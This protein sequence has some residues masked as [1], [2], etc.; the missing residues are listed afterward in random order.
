MII[1]MFVI[2]AI[3]A[4][5]IGY[6]TYALANTKKLK[7]TKVVRGYPQGYIPTGFKKK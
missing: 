4:F 2:L 3:S 7:N 5:F 6:G 1:A